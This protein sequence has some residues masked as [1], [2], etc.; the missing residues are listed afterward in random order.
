MGNAI[1][2]YRGC[3]GLNLGEIEDLAAL[4]G[5]RVVVP[6]PEPPGWSVARSQHQ[7][8]E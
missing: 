2:R 8:R 6:G 3:Q 4:T 7:D 1:D 5:V